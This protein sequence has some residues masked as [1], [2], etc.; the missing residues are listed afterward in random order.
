MN[1]RVRRKVE[2]GQ[3]ALA[4]S[5]TSAKDRYWDVIRAALVERSA[6]QGRCP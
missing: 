4:F 6:A 3:R 2:M 1:A 5:A